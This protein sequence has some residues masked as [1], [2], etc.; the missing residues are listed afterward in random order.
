[1]TVKELIA[2]LEKLPGDTQIGIVYMRCSDY[3]VLDED[4]LKF[5]PSGS[6]QLSRYSKV[7][8]FVLRNGQIMEY[9]EK[10]WDKN[11]VPN[12]VPVLAFPGN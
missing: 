8:R 7:R 6:I 11:E 5:F 10:T 3:Q 4:E 9:D 12:F 2:Y 1:M